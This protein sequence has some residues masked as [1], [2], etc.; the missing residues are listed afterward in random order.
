MMWEGLHSFQL[1][2]WLEEFASGKRTGRGKLFGTRSQPAVRSG[3]SIQPLR[4]SGD[5]IRALDQ[6][7]AANENCIRVSGV[8]LGRDCVAGM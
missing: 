7:A 6:D 1:G 8:R 3:L 4:K 5:E 2:R